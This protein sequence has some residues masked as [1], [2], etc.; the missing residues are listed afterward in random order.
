MKIYLGSDHAGFAL[1][2]VIKKFLEE[3]KYEVEDC[4]AYT[5]NKDDDY[6]DFIG[7]AAEGVSKDPEKNLGI[8]FGGSG[9]AEMIVANKYIGVRCGLFYTKALPIGAADVTGRTSSDPLEIVRLTKEHN[10]ANMLSLGARFLTEEDAISA[11]TTWL[12]TSFS[13]EE[14]H[15]RRIEKIKEIEKKI[16]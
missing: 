8:I 2:E 6:P 4:G 1:K 16:K 12:K 11:V 3:K 10:N 14:R 7:K 5:Y 9:E 13:A 15:I